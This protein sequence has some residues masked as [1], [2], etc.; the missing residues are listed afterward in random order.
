MKLIR[1]GQPGLEKP[2]VLDAEGRARDVSA[3]VPDFNPETIASPAFAQLLS[4][5]AEDYPL[6]PQGQ[7]LG[8]PIAGTRLIVAV[9]LNYADHAAEASMALPAEPALF[10]KSVHSICGPNDAT[11]LPPQA[12]KLDWEA[13]LGIIIGR[14]TSHVSEA[15]ALSYVLGYCVV[16]DVSER[17]YQL[18]RG[19]TWDKGKSCDTFTPV[20]PWLVT[21]DETGDAGTLDIWC[22][23]NGETMQQGSTAKMVFGPAALISY[24]SQ[25]F[26][27]HPGDLITTGTPAGVGFGKKP[28]RFLRVDD[29]VTLGIAGLGSQRQVVVE[30]R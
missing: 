26:T 3:L 25:F 11:L 30:K 2:A 10:M 21:P 22:K 19:G 29:V 9:G 6:A 14:V 18:E 27:L 5:K 1:H 16:N 12:E 17:S 23:V 7:R 24:I 13:E 8:A 4:S 28:Q 20:G 15:E